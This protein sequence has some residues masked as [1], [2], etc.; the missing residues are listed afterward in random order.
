MVSVEGLVFDKKLCI[1]FLFIIDVFFQLVTMAKNITVQYMKT[2]MMKIK[3]SFII[4]QIRVKD[5]LV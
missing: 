4:S 1:D 3:G 2:D 5:L